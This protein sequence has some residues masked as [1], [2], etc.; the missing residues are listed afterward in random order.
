M[1]LLVISIL[2]G[3]GVMTWGRT[4]IEKAVVQPVAAPEPTI[5]EDLNERLA[6]GEITKEQYDEIKQIIVAQNQR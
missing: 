3:I 2:I 6:K 4:Y 5:F 1:I